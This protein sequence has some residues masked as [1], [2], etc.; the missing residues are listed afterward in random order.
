MELNS[1][2]CVGT[3]V[4]NDQAVSDDHL[5]LQLILARMLIQEG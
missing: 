2:R 1:G 5:P 3:I 4:N